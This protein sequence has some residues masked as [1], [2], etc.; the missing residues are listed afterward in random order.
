[1]FFPQTT[2]YID[3]RL[4]LS[5]V[6][7]VMMVFSAHWRF[8]FKIDLLNKLVHA[9]PLSLYLPPLYSSYVAHSNQGWANLDQAHEDLDRNIFRDLSPT[10]KP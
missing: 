5:S 8:F 7:S 3:W 9:L 4:P 2:E 6:H 10:P 1:M